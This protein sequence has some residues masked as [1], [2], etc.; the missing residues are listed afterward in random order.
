MK[1]VK[2]IT[3]AAKNQDTKKTVNEDIIEL[4]VTKVTEKIENK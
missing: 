1:G 2:K 4:I 3:E